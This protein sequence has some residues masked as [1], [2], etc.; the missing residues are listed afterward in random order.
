MISR[1]L[2]SKVFIVCV[3]AV[4]IVVLCFLGYHA[5]FVFALIDAGANGELAYGQG[6]GSEVGPSSPESKWVWAA[7]DEDAFRILENLRHGSVV[8][9][10]AAERR[11][12]GRI[13]T[14]GDG[15]HVRAKAEL[16]FDGS[17]FRHA[18]R[19]SA[20]QEHLQRVLKVE[21]KTGYA[22]GQA[23]FVSA[24]CAQFRA[25]I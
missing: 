16:Y 22:E 15:T 23:V 2:M 10:Q 4:G 13:L 14:L 21:V 3:A 18:S 12:N 6:C 1:V 11:M 7:K 24:S 25:F 20:E 5:L 8:A 19:R 17:N 9:L